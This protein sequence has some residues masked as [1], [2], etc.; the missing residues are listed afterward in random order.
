MIEPYSAGVEV[1]GLNPNAV[2]VMG[3]AGVDISGH[4]S[5]HL[6]EL[7]DIDFDYVVTVCDNAH[8]S[9]PMFPGETQIVHVGFDDPPRLARAAKTEEEGLEI[10]RRVRD[11]IRRFVERL[12][13]SLK[14]K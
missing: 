7:K 10:Y 2:K 8:E 11:E 4:L 3:E 1:H 14:T 13:E 5:K 9:C 12:P 6:D